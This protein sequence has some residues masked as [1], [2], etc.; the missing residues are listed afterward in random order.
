VPPIPRQ[1]DPVVDQD[2]AGDEAVPHADS[3]AIALQAT[4]DLGCPTGGRLIE[5]EARQGRQQLADELLLRAGLGTR[6]ELEAR[7]DRRAQLARS[8]SRT[9]RSAVG[10]RPSRKSIRTS[11]SAII[12]ART[13]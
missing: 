2:D 3:H 9:R 13:S 7:D 5:R 1:Q 12:I 8:S 4:P 6:Q 10:E 11:V